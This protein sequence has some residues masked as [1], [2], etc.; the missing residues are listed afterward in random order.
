MSSIP[1]CVGMCRFSTAQTTM[2]TQ[3]A[4]DTNL[5]LEST[6]CISGTG[7]GSEDTWS[8]TGGPCIRT[9]PEMNCKV[10]GLSWP[11]GGHM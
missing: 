10:I 3:Y 8:L 1:V 2:F 4:L 6:T 5:L 7:A 9:T 11:M